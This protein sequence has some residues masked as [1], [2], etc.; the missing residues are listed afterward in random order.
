VSSVD[1]SPNTLCFLREVYLVSSALLHYG[2]SGDVFAFVRKSGSGATSVVN[3]V[4]WNLTYLDVDGV[5][6]LAGRWLHVL[7]RGFR[8][9]RALKLKPSGIWSARSLR[10][11]SL[12]TSVSA[13]DVRGSRFIVSVSGAWK[14]RVLF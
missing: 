5:C 12:V 1:T 9:T 3:A 6:L 2:H 4:W 10:F 7:G 11:R 8:S 14:I 13:K